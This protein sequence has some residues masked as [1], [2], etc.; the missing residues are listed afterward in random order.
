M[1]CEREVSMKCA[2]ALM[3]VVFV[4]LSAHRGADTAA[5]G[6]RSDMPDL[7]IDSG[8]PMLRA[9]TKAEYHAFKQAVKVARDRIWSDWDVSAFPG[10]LKFVEIP[11]HSW[12][13]Q[14]YKF[15]KLIMERPVNSTSSFIASFGGS[16]VT[17]GHDSYFHEAYPQVFY[18]T[19][20]PVFASLQV[21]LV[22]RNQALGNNPC[23]PYDACTATHL[24]DDAD[25]VTWEQS[26]NCGRDPRPVESFTRS[27]AAARKRPTVVYI[28]SGTPAWQP[29]DCVNITAAWLKTGNKTASA[30]GILLAKP[31]KEVAA[32]AQLMRAMTFLNINA[33]SSR[34][35]VNLAEL[36]RDAAPMA[37]SVLPLESYKCMGPYS[38]DFSTKSPGGGVAWHP[39]RKGH[40]LRADSLAFAFLSILDEVVAYLE[41]ALPSSVFSSVISKELL[42]TANRHISRTASNSTR[43]AAAC[44]ADVCGSEAQC[45][46]DYQ[47]RVKNALAS[48]IVDSSP[49][50]L[51]LP[52]CAFNSTEE[53]RRSMQA[54]LH[55]LAT[56]AS[57]TAAPSADGGNASW[58]FGISFFDRSAVDRGFSRGLGYL[59][60]KYIYAS[61]GKGSFLSFA[62]DLTR[63]GAVW[64]C[65]CQ[66]GFLKYPAT[67]GD[68]DGAADVFVSSGAAAMAP[69]SFSAGGA[70]KLRPLQPAA[71]QCYRTEALERGSHVV[72]VVQKGDQLINIAYLLYW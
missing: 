66:K 23:Y 38:P 33:Q 71:D 52:R 64:L 54:T 22:V 67:M 57:P 56:R 47:P 62:V 3:F 30:Q 46:T 69:Y 8:P 31:Y 4:V 10:F 44:S 39:G 72:T 19:M 61:G 43:E 7:N 55:A 1:G 41:T 63:C 42:D 49:I 68:L 11:N 14:K 53:G 32:A 34:G 9:V 24:G 70:T 59:D 48:R 50:L 20:K 17:A 45:Y 58:T 25:L 16:S 26:M 29:A 35:A 21:E 13:L 5:R 12:E 65:E 18:D 2:A 27:A 37:Q 40:K 60:R 28:A 6:Q 51:S 15:I 36:Y